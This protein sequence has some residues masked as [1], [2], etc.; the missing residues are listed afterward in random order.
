MDRTY[1]GNALISLT[2]TGK[3][4][5]ISRVTLRIGDGE[6]V[7]AGDDTAAELVSDCPWATQEMADALLAR[8]R[9]YAYHG[10][11]AGAAFA[12][13][14]AE[15]GDA[16]TVG[17]I[18]SIVASEDVN[19]TAAYTVALSA[20]VEG[21]VVHEYAIEG[22]IERQIKRVRKSVTQLTVKAGEISAEI[23]DV[24]NELSNRIELTAA[25]MDA[26]IE[27]TKNGL[28]NEITAT[29]E[30]L[31]ANISATDGR[32]T[33]LSASLDSMTLSVSNG[34]ESSTISL[35]KDGVTVSSKTVKFTGDV[36]FA[37]DLTDGTTMISGNNILT[38]TISADRLD[39]SG[40]INNVMED[41]VGAINFVYGSTQVGHLIAMDRSL[42]ELWAIDNMFVGSGGE[43]TIS[44]GGGDVNIDGAWEVNIT[45]SDGNIV[46]KPGGYVRIYATS[47]RFWEFRNTG[48]YYCSKSTDYSKVVIESL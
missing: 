5:P 4:Q 27:D 1:I 47:S 34:S 31:S 45:S 28:K 15:L 35:L 10:Y 13:P 25:G 30:S 9:G 42:F 24:E 21:D 41:G 23:T 12:D 48:I 40:A 36:I 7:T 38:G 8:L 22:A 14:A 33:A 18:Y 20:P 37:S 16:V 17:D 46:L 39:I 3:P 2:D 44:S 6:F 11:E 19:L 26:K 43:T 32:V 29:A